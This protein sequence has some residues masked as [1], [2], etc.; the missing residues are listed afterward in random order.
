M[1]LLSS[2]ANYCKKLKSA[3]SFGA[4]LTKVNFDSSSYGTIAGNEPLLQ[5]L[6]ATEGPVSVCL[7]VSSKFQAYSTGIC[8]REQ[9]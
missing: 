5:Q 3:S 1:N 8:E 7:Y 9:D 2:K 4:V 6:V